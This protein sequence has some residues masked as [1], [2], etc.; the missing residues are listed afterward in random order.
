MTKLLGCRNCR[1][2]FKNIANLSSHR[3]KNHAQS[4]SAEIRNGIKNSHNSPSNRIQA[5]QK[6]ITEALTL[7][8]SISGAILTRNPII[9]VQAAKDAIDLLQAVQE[10]RK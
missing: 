9:A 10:L 5:Q 4:V 6:A 3:R 2:K 8:G 7:L 1:C